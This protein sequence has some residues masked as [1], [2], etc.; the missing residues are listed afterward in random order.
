[1]KLLLGEWRFLPPATGSRHR[2]SKGYYLGIHEVTQNQYLRAIGSQWAVLLDHQFSDVPHSKSNKKCICVM[3]A[4]WS[5]DHRS[6]ALARVF[7]APAVTKFME[8]VS[9]TRNLALFVGLI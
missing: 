7:D 6:D 3:E 9:W 5:N 2:F 1:M 8:A 4:P